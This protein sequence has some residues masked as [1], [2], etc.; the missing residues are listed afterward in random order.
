MHIQQFNAVL[1]LNHASATDHLKKLC[2]QQRTYYGQR[3][4]PDEGRAGQGRAG[5]GRVSG[6]EQHNGVNKVELELVCLEVTE[7]SYKLACN[8]VQRTT[9]HL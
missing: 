9:T 5:Q 6:L 1:A 4:G 3:D 2:K 7:P 8:L